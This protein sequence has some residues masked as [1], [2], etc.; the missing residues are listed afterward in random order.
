MGMGGVNRLCASICLR[1][2][3]EYRKMKTTLMRMEAIKNYEDA[4]RLQFRDPR[5]RK[6]TN[7]DKFEERIAELKEDILDCEDFFDSEMF[8]NCTG[9][10]GE[11][12]IKKILKLR[13]EALQT[14]ERRLTNK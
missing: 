10:C 13:P 11:D 9:I 8:V 6:K 2:V 1:A 5:G 4:M 3:V 14:I 12:A 7:P